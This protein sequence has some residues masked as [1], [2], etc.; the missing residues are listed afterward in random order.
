MFSR[1]KRAALKYALINMYTHIVDPSTPWLWTWAGLSTLS[2]FFS[3]FLFIYAKSKQMFQCYHLLSSVS[4]GLPFYVNLGN[5]VWQFLAVSFLLCLRVHVPNPLGLARPS[6][7]GF[8]L[9]GRCA[10]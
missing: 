2:F 6:K 9:Q 5:S 3:F 4:R 8:Q 1:Y 7:G 10:F